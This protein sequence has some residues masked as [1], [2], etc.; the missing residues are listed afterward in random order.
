MSF[1]ARYL[2]V[3]AGAAAAAADGR[4]HDAEEARRLRIID[5]V[6]G[7]LAGNEGLEEII[8]PPT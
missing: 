4:R 8:G 5:L 6:A 1:L 2:S 3:F 7:S